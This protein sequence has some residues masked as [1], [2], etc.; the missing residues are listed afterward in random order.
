MGSTSPLRAAGRE[1]VVDDNGRRFDVG[2]R[3]RI[4][5]EHRQSRVEHEPASNRT[6][7]LQIQP[8]G[9]VVGRVPALDQVVVAHARAAPAEPR[10][11]EIHPQHL[12]PRQR[13]VEP[14]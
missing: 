5:P 9:T 8:E 14:T 2:P 12:I 1:R 3:L 10:T 4:A 13:V 11:V 6:V 7:L